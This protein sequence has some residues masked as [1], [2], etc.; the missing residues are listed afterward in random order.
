MILQLIL[1]NADC[2]IDSLC[3][4]LLQHEIQNTKAI[5]WKKNGFL[6]TGPDI[7]IKLKAVVLTSAEHFGLYSR[8]CKEGTLSEHFSTTTHPYLISALSQLFKVHS[9]DYDASTHNFSLHLHYATRLTTI[10]IMSLFISHVV[11]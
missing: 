2:R 5:Y 4:A 3:A 10:L 11:F 8:N 1:R 9:C 7:K 6:F